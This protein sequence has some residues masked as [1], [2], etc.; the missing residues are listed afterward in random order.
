MKRGLFFVAIAYQMTLFAD[1]GPPIDVYTENPAGTSAVGIDNN[2]NA[3]IGYSW[4][5]FMDANAGATQLIDGVPTNTINFP[6]AIFSGIV[7]TLNIAVNSSGNATLVWTEFNGNFSTEFVRSASFLNEA[8]SSPIALTDPS[9]EN[10]QTNSPPGITIDTAN[11]SLGIWAPMNSTTSD[12]NVRYD[13]YSSGMWGGE[14]NLNT[15]SSDFIPTAFISGSPSG[16]AFALWPNTGL[17]QLQGAYFNGTSWMVNSNISSDLNTSCIA[18]IAVSMNSS[19]HALILWNNESLGGVSSI[20]FSG[21][22]YGLE[23]QVFVPFAGEI[24][25]SVAVALDEADD[26]AAIWVAY[27]GGTFT[28]TLYFASFIGGNWG[29]LVLLDQILGD[30]AGLLSLNIGLDGAGNAVIVWQRTN[31][32][33]TTGVMASYMTKGAINA[34][35]PTLLSTD[36]TDGVAPDLAVNSSGQAVACWQNGAFLGTA[37][38]AAIGNFSIAPTPPLNLNGSQVKNRFATQIDLVN[39]LNWNAS[40]DPSVV[41]YFIFRDGMR[42]AIVS[43]SSPLTYRDHNRSGQTTLYE[44]TAVDENDSESA[45]VSIY[46]P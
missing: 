20:L 1:W 16:Q 9:V 34:P 39:V 25:Q 36:T 32:D 19:N 2:G 21:G 46:I 43:A 38:Q 41:K 3:M 40:V 5:H 31:Q 42:I 13:Q 4:L 17:F 18:P 22:S 15:P 28:S 29:P 10:V 6:V 7:N 37:I 23:Q 11:G 45:P 35:V 26:G 33:T 44:V 14:T 24:V 30:M 12:F 8:W 27:D